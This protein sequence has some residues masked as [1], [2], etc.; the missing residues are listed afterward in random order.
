LAAFGGPHGPY[1]TYTII[2]GTPGM[3]FHKV[4]VDPGTGR[5]LASEEISGKE[6]MR[7]QQMHQMM[8][9]SGSDGPGGGGMMMMEDRGMMM[10]SEHGWK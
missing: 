8:H 5:V 3:E 7:M 9:G 2:L 10:K 4:I 6:W 1:L